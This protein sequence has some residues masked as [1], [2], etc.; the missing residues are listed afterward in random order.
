MVVNKN[1]IIISFKIIGKINKEWKLL[2]WEVERNKD[3]RTPN[4]GS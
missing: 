1:F 3:S 4:R 2:G